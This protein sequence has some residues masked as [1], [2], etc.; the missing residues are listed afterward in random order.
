MLYFE[1]GCGG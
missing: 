1:E